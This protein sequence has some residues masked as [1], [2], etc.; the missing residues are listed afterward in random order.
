MAVAGN[1]V[2]D[3]ADLVGI[4][5]D[6]SPVAVAGIAGIAGIVDIGC[7][8][9]NP[10]DHIVKGHTA[11]VVVHTADTGPVAH[12]V[13]ELSEP[14]HL[15]GYRRWHKNARRAHFAVR[16]WCKSCSLAVVSR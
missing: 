16:N 5:V 14:Q 10:I 8:V 15:L 3:T 7:L 13:V 11:V 12:T 9:H 1:P 4:E 6:H 2:A